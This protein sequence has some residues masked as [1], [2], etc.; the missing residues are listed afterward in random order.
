MIYLDEQYSQAIL[1]CHYLF[2]TE[3]IQKIFRK[4]IKIEKITQFRIIIRRCQRIELSEQRKKM[5]Q[6]EDRENSFLTNPELT[7]LLSKGNTDTN[8]QL[9]VIEKFIKCSTTHYEDFGAHPD[10]D[11]YDLYLDYWI[12]EATLAAFALHFG[13][14]ASGSPDEAKAASALNLFQAFQ[15][16]LTLNLYEIDPTTKREL[17]ESASLY[18]NETIHT[19]ASH[20]RIMRFKEGSFKKTGLKEK[21]Y[22]KSLSDGEYQLIHT[23]GLC[24]LFRHKPC[25]FLLDEPETHLNPD[26]RASYISTLR[27]A[28]EVNDPDRPP[29]MREVLLT[30]HSPFIISDCREENVLVFSKYEKTDKVTWSRPNFKTFGASANA[31]TMK[32][33]GQTETIGDYAMETLK[34]LRERL[35][36]GEDP[37]DLIKVADQ[38]LGDSVEKVLFVNQ[39][40]QRREGK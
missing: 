18:V 20:D 40:I 31:I 6:K 35:E 16:L 8:S 23:I 29:V 34:Q 9:G 27:D 10:D 26:W 37:D 25:L 38:E 13:A 28:L 2:P 22:I 7:S 1:L 17:Y 5:M 14:G 24:L 36:R 39:A 21:L 15:T 30:S 32:I 19:P 3:A 12:D 33:F 11:S 4:R